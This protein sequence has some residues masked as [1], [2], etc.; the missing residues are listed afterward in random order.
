MSNI[1][2][3]DNLPRSH[4]EESAAYFLGKTAS[5][6]RCMLTGINLYLKEQWSG[7]DISLTTLIISK[8]LYRSYPINTKG[9][10]YFNVL[11]SSVSHSNEHDF[12]NLFWKWGG[13]H[14]YKKLDLFPGLKAQQLALP[15]PSGLSSQGESFHRALCRGCDVTVLQGLQVMAGASGSEGGVPAALHQLH[16]THVTAAFSLGE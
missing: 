3:L 12:C 16:F 15:H 4:R 14:G 9:F 5:I 10:F 6:K 7:R 1:G 8:S 11:C 13:E 2:K